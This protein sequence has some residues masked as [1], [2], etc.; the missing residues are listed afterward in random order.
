MG[1]GW[2]YAETVDISAAGAFFVTKRQFSPHALIEY[3]LTFPSELTK[4][5]RNLRMRFS[6]SVVRCERIP[7][8]SGAYGVAVRHNTHR[9]LTSEEVSYFDSLDKSLGDTIT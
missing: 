9:Y 3:V 2:V 4:A 7:G 1:D 5:P 8:E 6:A